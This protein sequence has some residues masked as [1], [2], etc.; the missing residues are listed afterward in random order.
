M[1]KN[2]VFD[3]DG[4]IVDSIDLAVELYN[5]LAEKY[6]FLKINKED[7]EYLRSLS[8]IEKCKAL[9]V[10]L[11][12]LPVFGIEFMRNYRKSL[13]SLKTFDGINE[14]IIELKGKGYKLN[15]ISSNSHENVSEL[16]KNNNIDLFDS[17]NC[18]SSIFGKDKAIHNFIKKYS[19]NREELV[20]IGDENRDVIACKV[21][22][23]KVIAVSWGFD[24]IEL[25]TRAR[26]DFIVNSPP[27]IV[28]LIGLEL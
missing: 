19:L 1:I 3:F 24:S 28:G 17:I 4:T 23:I 20:Y 8:V 15:I 14:V 26:P 2:I 5:E 21:N 11:Y 22:Q 18:I 27:E 6:R 12:K 13:G 7:F 25:L 10:P 16:L 9:H